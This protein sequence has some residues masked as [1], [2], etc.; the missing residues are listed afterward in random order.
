MKSQSSSSSPI[1]D[2]LFD[3]VSLLHKKAEGLEATEK[4]LRDAEE[5]NSQSC[6]DILNRIIEQDRQV[7]VELR[8][9]LADML[10]NREEDEQQAEG[11]AAS[12]SH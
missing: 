3:F 5:Q 8:D 4:Y 10:Q 7:V 9:H 2:L 1:S 12:V 6:I 11:Q